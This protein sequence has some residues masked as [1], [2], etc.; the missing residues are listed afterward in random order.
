MATLLAN[1]NG[2]VP[3]GVSTVL[4]TLQKKKQSK[5]HIL[6]Y[7]GVKGQCRTKEKEKRRKNKYVSMLIDN[8]RNYS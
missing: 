5:T 2:S 4:P 8:V 3:S 1:L 7:N 6:S